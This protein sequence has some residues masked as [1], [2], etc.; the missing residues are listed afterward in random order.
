M[1]EYELGKANDLPWLIFKL[2]Q[3][4]FAVNSVAISSIF[5]LEQEVTAVPGYSENVRGILSLRGEVIPI[6]EL[7]QIMEIISF[8]KEH[9]TFSEM[10]D[11]RKQDH[12]N[13]MNELQNCIETNENCSNE[14][15]LATDPHKCAFGK[16]YYSYKTND[17]N[18]TFHLNKIEDPHNKLHQTAEKIFECKNISDKDLRKEKV[19]ELITQAKSEYVPTILKLID[20]TKDV[21][22]GSHREMCIVLTNEEHSFGILVDEVCSVEE[23]EFVGTESEIKKMLQTD[24]VVGIAQCSSVEGQILVLN[25]AALFKESEKRNELIK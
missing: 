4:Y 22:K 16:W 21:M 14:F 17:Q 23:I 15:N 11:M 1:T 3:R 18:V 12:V 10:L 24:L 7:R 6:L 2:Q 19:H 25:K 13:W 20:E 9:Q 8:E 5:Q